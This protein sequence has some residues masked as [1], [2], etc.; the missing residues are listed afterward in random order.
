[1]ADA[2]TPQPDDELEP[3]EPLANEPESDEP[4]PDDATE[5]AD[6]DPDAPEQE[7][8]EP[9]VAARTGPD[10]SQRDRRVRDR[11]LRRLVDEEV[12]KRLSARTQRPQIDYAAQQ[13][14]R[15]EQRKRELEDARMQ[16]PEAYADTRDRHLRE[17]YNQDR[18][19]QAVQ[20]ADERD[21]LRFDRLCDREPIYDSMRDDVE[22]EIAN[23]RGNGYTGP[24]S[25]EAVAE[26]M[27][28][29]RQIE[30]AKGS[31]R[32]QRR[33]AAAAAQRQN[34]RS[35]N[36]GAPSTQPA[37]RGSRRNFADLSLAEME[38]QLAR[39]P[40]KNS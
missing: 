14:V 24:I 13:R 30:R 3:D 35:S 2:D 11:E 23:I 6:D 20:Q 33:N 9:P 29:K 7:P 16:G 15:D 32:Q 39:I 19:I 37:S 4:P 21:Q 1:M 26:R 18:Q 40:I 8:D 17:D 31:A 27:F 34:G 10:A 28:G 22:R 5:A 25:R 36:G 38:Q 12:E